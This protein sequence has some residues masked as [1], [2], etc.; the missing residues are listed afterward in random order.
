MAKNTRTKETLHQGKPRPAEVNNP[1][2]EGATPEQVGRA[3]LRQ[4]PSEKHKKGD[5]KAA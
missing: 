4:R 5:P 1:A 3:L 2:Y